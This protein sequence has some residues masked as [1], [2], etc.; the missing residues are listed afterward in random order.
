MVKWVES[1]EI[2]GVIRQSFLR[3]PFLL[4]IQRCFTRRFIPILRTQG[5]GI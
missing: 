1:M 3:F 5:R 4:T 2:L